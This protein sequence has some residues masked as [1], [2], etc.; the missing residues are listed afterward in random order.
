MI[1]LPDGEV[2]KGRC[3]HLDEWLLESSC[4]HLEGVAGWSESFLL[5]WPRL[6]CNQLQTFWFRKEGHE[7]QTMIQTEYSDIVMIRDRHLLNKHP[8]EKMIKKRRHFWLNSVTHTHLVH[9]PIPVVQA[10]DETSVCGKDPLDEYCSRWF[11]SGPDEWFV[12][13]QRTTEKL[14]NLN[15]RRNPLLIVRRLSALDDGML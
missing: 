3:H 14:A 9:A 1:L 6:L 15:R 5:E 12:K 8:C 4:A 10:N 13:T 7:I 11:R 2:G